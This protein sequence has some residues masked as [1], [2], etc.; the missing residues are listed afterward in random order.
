VGK[1][2]RRLDA[3]EK[4]RERKKPYNI[5]K[6]FERYQNLYNAFPTESVYETHEYISWWDATRARIPAPSRV[7]RRVT[8][9]RFRINV[10]ITLHYFN[11][12]DRYTA[13]ENILGKYDMDNPISFHI[14][15]ADAGQIEDSLRIEE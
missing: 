13:L 9:N 8:F 6:W 1:T 14:Q 2:K 10:W 7:E 11:D 3:I 5:Y 4:N 15:V 12:R